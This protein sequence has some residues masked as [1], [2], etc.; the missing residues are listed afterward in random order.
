ME[1]I[2]QLRTPECFG[3]WL[4]SITNRMAINRLVRNKQVFATEP[5]TM[6]STVSNS[7]KFAILRFCLNV[8]SFLE[9]AFARK[10]TMNALDTR[11]KKI[12]KI[13]E[14]VN[15]AQNGDREAFGELF[16][17]FERSVY[18]VA[19]RRM[20]NTNEAEELVQDVFI[21]AME[22]IDQLRTPECFGGWLQSITNRMAINR[23]VRNKQVF[24]TEP[25]TMASTVSEDRTPL[26]SALDVE[27]RERVRSGMNQ[28][29]DM[30]RET[31]YAFYMEG[32]SLAEMSDSFSAP[33]GTIKRRLHVAR[34]RLAEEIEEVVA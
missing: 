19:F 17:Q 20:K 25:E 30:D 8:Q 3:G 29:R 16:I 22:K 23:L 18:A 24:A 11:I 21:K 33:V 12:E 26:D 27:A 2:D 4:Q 13:V 34:K 9:Q 1:K 31:L 14:L 32:Q 5:E 15:A 6:A 10:T 7:H 28:L